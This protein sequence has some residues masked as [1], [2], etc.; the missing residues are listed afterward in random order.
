MGDA[1]PQF[2]HIVWGPDWLCCV[3]PRLCPGWEI[4]ALR[5]MI[6]HPRVTMWEV[7]VQTF[8]AEL[9]LDLACHYRCWPAVGSVWFAGGIFW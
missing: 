5:A 3:F 1:V 2:R 6:S 7:K 8:H 9:R 4:S